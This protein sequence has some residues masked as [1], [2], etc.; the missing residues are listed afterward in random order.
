[1]RDIIHY[2][3]GKCSKI[4]NTFLFFSKNKVVIRAGTNKMLSEKKTGKALIRLLIKKQSDLVCPV[5][6]A[7]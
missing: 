2:T 6:Q 5:C 4:S 1:M 7:L 3:C